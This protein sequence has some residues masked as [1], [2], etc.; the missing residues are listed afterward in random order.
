MKKFVRTFEESVIDW[1]ID[2]RIALINS[3]NQVE[4]EFLNSFYKN[5]RILRILQ[6]RT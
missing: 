1:Y 5:R 3:W 2:L 6:L 4:V